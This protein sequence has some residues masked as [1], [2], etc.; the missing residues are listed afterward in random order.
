MNG[1]TNLKAACG[2]DKG[3]AKKL[4]TLN[5]EAWFSTPNI[6]DIDEMLI[7]V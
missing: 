5:L 4:G 6:I 1:A 7:G 3:A 2:P